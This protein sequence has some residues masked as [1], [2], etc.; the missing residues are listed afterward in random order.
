MNLFDAPLDPYLIPGTRVLKNLLG[1]K[2][3]EELSDY[4]NELSA[5][6][7]VLIREDPP[8]SEGTVEQLRWIH[9][10]LFKDIYPWAGELHTINMSKGDG[11]P[12][13]YV[14]RMDM[15]IAYCEG[16]LR[17][18]KLFR[19]MSRDQLIERLSVNYDNFNTL[20][21]FRE[22]NGRTQRLFWELVLHDAG[23]HVDWGLVNK[24]INDTASI[25]AMENLDYSKLESMFDT[26]VKP[27]NE[28][29]LAGPDLRTMTDGEYRTQP[30]VSRK[31]TA[32][33]Y[34]RLDRKYA[35]EPDNPKKQ[36]AKELFNAE[37]AKRTA[38]RPAQNSP[39]H[40]SRPR[41]RKGK[42]R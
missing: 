14:E 23:W 36:T 3:G 6:G 20:H 16:T 32:E 27:L 22:G 25:A 31:L 35:R 17:D 29:L 18:D 28:P 34:R 11:Q 26:V 21:P 7:A 13:H 10:M 12:F 24:Q 40:P 2:T 4:E 5:A 15:G 42:D 37:V 9:R 8:H 33:E 1:A 30:N 19:G 38:E 41:D 39:S